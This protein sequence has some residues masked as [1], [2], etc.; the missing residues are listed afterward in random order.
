MSLNLYGGGISALMS[1][2]C[3]GWSSIRG[4]GLS[5]RLYQNSRRFSILVSGRIPTGNRGFKRKGLARD[6]GNLRRNNDNGRNAETPGGT[7][8]KARERERRKLAGRR[9]RITKKGAERQRRRTNRGAGRKRRRSAPY[10]G[11]TVH[12]NPTRQSREI[13]GSCDE[14]RDRAVLEGIMADNIIEQ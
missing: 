12:Q 8:G 1:M 6:R 4:S 14:F 5:G 3:L 7:R 13:R 2:S 10:V 9:W 11:T